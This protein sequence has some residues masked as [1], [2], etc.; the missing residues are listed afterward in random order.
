[1]AGRPRKPA[2]VERARG[3]EAQR[4]TDDAAA[5]MRARLRAL[6][7]KTGRGEKIPRPADAAGQVPVEAGGTA[8]RAPAQD[9]AASASCDGEVAE[10]HDFQDMARSADDSASAAAGLAQDMPTHGGVAGQDSDSSSGDDGLSAPSRKRRR[11]Q[12]TPAQRALG[13]LVRRE[14]S[15]KELTRKLTVRGVD[16]DEAR[17]AVE[18]MREAG[19][20]DDARFAESLVRSRAFGGHGP[21]R[22]RAELAT[23]GLDRELIDTA[24]DGFEGDF[25]GIARELV[26]RRHGPDIASDRTVQRKAAE[27]L[28]RRGYSMDQIRAATRFDPDD[29]DD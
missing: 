7:E 18:R 5:A 19:W 29:M 24:L 9:G 4:I 14:H 22:I 10:V 21:I 26:R 28:V 8:M 13:L 12:P 20:Q 2:P 6:M 15:R 25:T 23:H 17:A 16:K 27:L 3:R 11:P 1:M